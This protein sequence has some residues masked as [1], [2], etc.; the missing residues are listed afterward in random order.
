MFEGAKRGCLH[1]KCLPVAGV[2]QVQEPGYREGYEPESY[3]GGADG[4]DESAGATVVGMRSRAAPDAEDLSKK[5]NEKNYAAENKCEP[6]HG[7]PFY[8]FQ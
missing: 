4:D 5:T 6:C 3:D 8:S 2:L 1:G 7:H